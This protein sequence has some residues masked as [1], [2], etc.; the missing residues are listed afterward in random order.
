[1]ATKDFRSLPLTQAVNGCHLDLLSIKFQADPAK[2]NFSFTG[3]RSN[4][5]QVVISC[6]ARSHDGISIQDELEKLA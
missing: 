1:M 6:F 4:N 2:A 3:G 5:D